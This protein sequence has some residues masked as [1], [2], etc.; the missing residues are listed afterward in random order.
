MRPP[1]P[2]LLLMVLFS[3]CSVLQAFKCHFASCHQVLGLELPDG[4]DQAGI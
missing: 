4:R 3:I 2:V 1:N